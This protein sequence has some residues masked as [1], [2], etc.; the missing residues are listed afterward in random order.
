MLDNAV[1]MGPYAPNYT[2]YVEN[3]LLHSAAIGVTPNE[4]MYGVK[5]KLEFLRTFG[6]TSYVLI[7]KQFRKK[8]DKA[9][10]VGVFLNCSDNHKTYIA[11]IPKT[12]GS[13]RITQSRNVKFEEK[14][15]FIKHAEL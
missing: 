13:L 15:M 12:D 9:A 4:R 6:C 1:L 11:R 10:E 14:K 3:Y 5:P 8:L 7:E 2:F